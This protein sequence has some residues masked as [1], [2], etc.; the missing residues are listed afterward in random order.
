[1]EN[2]EMTLDKTS[3]VLP[4]NVASMYTL[5]LFIVL[6]LLVGFRIEKEVRHL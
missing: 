2:D 4:C 5:P 6:E 1:M 3:V